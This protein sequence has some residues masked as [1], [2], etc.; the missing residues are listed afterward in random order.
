ME[1]AP[2]IKMHHA[3]RA[4]AARLALMLETEYPRLSLVALEGEAIDHETFEYDLAGFEVRV[5]EEEVII[6]TEG[7]DLPE[8]ADII[9]ACA[10]QEIDPTSSGDDEEEK[11]SGSVVKEAY[12]VLYREVSSNGQNCGDW[13]A[14]RMVDDTTGA[15]G[16]LN[17]DDLTALFEKNGLNL[18][19][20]WALGRFTQTRGWQG[21]YRMSGRIK[22]ECL[23]T[24]NKMYVDPTGHQVLPPAG[25]LENMEAKHA[26]FLAKER[27]RI[28]DAEKAIKSS[29]EG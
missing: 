1:F 23:V 25:W 22:L 21:R 12:R 19:E 13:L 26:K 5:D 15:D 11:F 20:K 6:E 24:L 9:D 16:H 3:T 29:V 14:E 8:L 7:K 27:K 28:A 18:N 10:E 4:K 2:S 17:I